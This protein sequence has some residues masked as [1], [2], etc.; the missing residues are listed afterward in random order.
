MAWL[1][2]ILRISKREHNEVIRQILGQTGSLTDKIRQRRL[3]WFGH[4]TRMNETRLPART[5]YSYVEGTR[6][7]GRQRNNWIDN[8]KEDLD[9]HGLGLQA[10]INMTRNQEQ[11]RRRAKSSSLET[12]DG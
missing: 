11:W 1:R 7:R 4:V 3:I 8:V 12:T 5:I 2:R 10:A 6:S 9:F